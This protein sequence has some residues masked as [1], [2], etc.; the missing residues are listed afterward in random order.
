MLE[1]PLILLSHA[2]SGG[3][4]VSLGLAF[5]SGLLHV[6]RRGNRWMAA[7]SLCLSTVFIQ[8]LVE[9][10]FGETISVGLLIVLELPRWAIVP[11]FY[12]AVRF[13]LAPQCEQKAYL[14]HFIPTIV[15]CT[16]LFAPLLGIEIPTLPMLGIWLVRYFL[17]IQV[18]GYGVACALLIRNHQRNVP[19][20]T[21]D[22]R[23]VDLFW[24]E[25]L[26]I[27][28]VL[29]G[30]WKVTGSVFFASAW[31]DTG[32]Y[33]L[34]ILYFAY[35]MLFQKAI[36]PVVDTDVSDLQDA[37]SDRPSS[38]RE[39]LTADQLA[40]FVNRLHVLMEEE[41]YFLDPSLSLPALAS[42][43][44]L[45]VHELSYV[46]NAGVRMNF[47]QYINTLRLTEA[48][49]LLSVKNTQWSVQ[50]VAVRSGFNSKTTFYS[51]FKKDTGLT[52]KQ[53]ILQLQTHS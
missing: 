46:L 35:H 12:M 2:L 28:F 33:L 24:I 40:L 19:R 43:L 9:L 45:S 32:L 20:F 51:A 41:R 22:V 16:L 13:Y 27:A 52:P 8:Q 29:M 50:E 17:Y 39:R 30:F 11:C 1:K 38:D 15:L 48:K 36:Y 42:K 49:R 47:Y 18:F 37:I 3:I 7:F 44:H 34:L 31:L 26:L 23:S 14:L 25:A 4:L 6:N 10:A 21:S 5:F 53:Y